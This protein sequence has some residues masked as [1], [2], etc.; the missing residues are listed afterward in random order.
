MIFASWFCRHTWQQVSSG[1][2][3][4]AFELMVTAGYKLTHVQ[5]VQYFKKTFVCVLK[6]DGCGTLKTIK[7]SNP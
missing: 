7:E 3:P 2:L 4:S 1:T 5:P 6:C